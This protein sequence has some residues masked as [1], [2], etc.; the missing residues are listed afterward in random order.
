[1]I[2]L[3]FVIL[4]FIYFVLQRW[5]MA[6][7]SVCARCDENTI[8]RIWSWMNLEAMDDIFNE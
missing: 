2:L 5:H 6:C 3:L 8:V 4:L 1:M 7:V